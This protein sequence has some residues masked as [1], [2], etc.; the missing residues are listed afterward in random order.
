MT[1]DP[2]EH[3]LVNLLGATTSDSSY[4]RFFEEY[5]ITQ[6]SELA[7]ITENRLATVSYG[8]LTPSV[9]D[10][11][12]TIVCMFL[13]PAQQDR[14]LKI[15][16]WF[17]SKGTNVTNKTWLELT[18]EVLEYWQPASAIVAPATPVG[19]DARSSSV[20]SAAAKFRKTI[21]NHF[22]PYPKFSEDRFWVTWNTNIRIKLRVHGVQL[23]LDPDY[24]PETVDETD[25][26]VEMQNFAF[27]VFNNILLT[28]RAHGILHKHVDELDAQ[29]V[30]R[31]LVASYGKGINAQITATSIET[32]LTLYSFATSKSK[33]CV[34]FL[35]TWRNLIYDLERINEFPL[36]DHQKSVQLKSAV[37]SH[38]QL[39]LFLGNVQLYSRTHVGMSANDSNFEYDYDLMLKHATDIDQTDLEDR[40]KHRSGRSANNAKSQSSSKKKTNKPIGKKHKNY[41]PPEK[42]NALSPE[43]KRTI[44]DQQGPRPVPPPAPALLVNAAAT[45]PPPMVY[46]SDSMAVDNQSLASTHV[47]PAAGPGQLL[48]SLISNSAARQHPAPWNGAT[49]DSFSVNGTTYCREVNHASVQYRLSTHDVSLNKDSL[50]DGGANGGLSGSDV[51]VILQSLLEATVSGIGNS[52]LTNLCLSTV[53]GLIHTTDGPI[54]GVFHQYAHL[55]T[56]NTIH[57]CNQM[58]SWGVTVDDVPRT[59]GGKQRIITS[60]GRFVIPLSVSGGLT[61]LS[62]QA[63]TEEDLDYFEWVPFTADNEWDPTG[64]SSPAAADDDL[65]LQLPAGHVPFRDERINNF[66]LLAHSA[67]VS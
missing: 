38:P 62:M 9:G 61:Y 59:F 47:P 3:V 21:K 48:R 30:Y 20:K 52:E 34:A 14:I 24:L 37:R 46:V 54:F 65:S 66:G 32:K 4:R 2:L 23:V 42:W 49:S 55:G 50:I 15:V 11:P 67:A 43:E 56:G 25:T 44:M 5:G 64:V 58:R 12:A 28:P 63:P 57:L 29:A 22:V 17:L 35:T 7:S 41:V 27:G 33:T 18:P 26:F 6:A 19:S 40:G 1:M 36:P 45:Q 8:V 31:D 53:A 51:T 60:D 13:P 16:K 10:T 39:K